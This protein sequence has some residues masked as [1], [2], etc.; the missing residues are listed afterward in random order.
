MLG[1]LE[2]VHISPGELGFADYSLPCPWLAA[3]QQL[4]EKHEGATVTHR[5]VLS[6]AMYPKVFDEYMTFVDNYSSA[7]EKL[8]TRAFLAPLEVREGALWLLCV[9]PLLP[10]CGGRLWE[11]AQGSL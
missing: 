4:R 8:P 6:A 10:P 9:A 2:R 1:R 7:V 5:D 11:G 3:W